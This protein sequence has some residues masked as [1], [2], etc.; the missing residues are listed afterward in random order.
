MLVYRIN[1]HCKRLLWIGRHRKLRTLLG[2]RW[3]GPERCGKLRYVCSEFWKPYL[4]VFGK[5]SALKNS[6]ISTCQG[7]F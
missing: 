7:S 5:M 3:F 2:F 1:R 4:R 6:A